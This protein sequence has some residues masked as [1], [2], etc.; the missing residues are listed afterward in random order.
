MAVM[1]AVGMN[2]TFFGGGNIYLLAPFLRRKTKKS[3]VETPAVA[4]TPI[5]PAAP[6]ESR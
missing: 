3:P 1:M 4:S 6:V 5:T 2:L